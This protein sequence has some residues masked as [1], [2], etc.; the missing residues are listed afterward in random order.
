M[1]QYYVRINENNGFYSVSFMD[2][3]TTVKAVDY[4]NK[5]ATVSDIYDWLNKPNTN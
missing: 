2:W 4:V 3:A 1:K 5:E